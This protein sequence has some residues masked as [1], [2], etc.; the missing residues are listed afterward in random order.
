MES[1]NI[2]EW[3]RDLLTKEGIFILKQIKD[4]F[5]HIFHWLKFFEEFIGSLNI[6]FY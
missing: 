2:K 3:D 6:L 1:F 5:T 4:H